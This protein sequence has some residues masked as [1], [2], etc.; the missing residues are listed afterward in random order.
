[1]LAWWT[2]T[3]GSATATIV[4]GGPDP[5]I[6]DRLLTLLDAAPGATVLDVACGTANYTSVLANR[7]LTMVGV[8]LSRVMLARARTKGVSLPLVR[9]DG[10]ALPF[11]DGAFAHAVTTLA[12]HHMADLT[13][14]FAGVRRVVAEGGRYVIF[15]ALPEQV[16]GYWLAT[17]FPTIMGA[18]V[19]ACPARETV[20]EALSNAGFR[21]AHTEP[22]DV[23]PDLTDLF[24]YAGK[25]RPELYFDAGFRN[26]ISAFREHAS[27]ELDEGL[28]K[29]RADL[30]SGRWLEVRASADRGRGDYCFFV[31]EAN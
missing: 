28:A 24:L 2:H 21:L 7:G 30:D 12:I 5:R 25:D 17:Y 9:A 31:A 13:A 8:D 1:M 22:W 10:A 23:P 4:P 11:T 14:V 19:R 27:A 3:I 20:D 16:R 26:G 6:A 15:S 18:A 29:L